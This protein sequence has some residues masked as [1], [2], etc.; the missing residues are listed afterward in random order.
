MDNFAVYKINKSTILL[1]CLTYDSIFTYIDDVINQNEIK[2]SCGILIVDQLLVVG[3]EDNRFFSAPFC[4]GEIFFNKSKP[5]CP[6]ATEQYKKIS[7]E[8]LRSKNDLL[9]YSILSDRQK[10][11][12]DAG[13]FI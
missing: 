11:T 7:S 10:D 13:G 8:I 3:D 1:L 9:E 2:H 4:Y 5:I 6:M 12:L